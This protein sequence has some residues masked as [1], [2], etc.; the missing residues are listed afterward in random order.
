LPP[1][2]LLTGWQLS[3]AE[4]ATELLDLEK[5][6]VQASF[7]AVDRVQREKEAALRREAERSR[8]TANRFRILSIATAVFA[9]IAIYA[10]Y[11]AWGEI[12]KKIA[13][14]LQAKA[15]VLQAMR[16]QPLNYV[17][18]QLDLALLLA[19]EANREEAQPELRRALLTALNA[20]L[21]L[22]LLISGGHND[23]VRAVAFN[24]DG[25]IVASGSYDSKI[26]LWDAEQGKMLL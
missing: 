16:L 15:R 5:E 24:P 10:V 17:D 12:A 19:I 6:Y 1:E 21:E 22:K 23:G 26:I 20:N 7:E 14:E 3:A 11:V 2:G 4:S 13:L 18:D 8:A 25:Q 9:A